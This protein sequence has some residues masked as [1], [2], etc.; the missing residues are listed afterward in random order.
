MSRA[1]HCAAAPVRMG[2]AAGSDGRIRTARPL[3]PGLHRILTDRRRRPRR[4]RARE[5]PPRLRARPKVQRTRRLEVPVEDRWRRNP[6]AAGRSRPA[7]AS[8]RRYGRARS[9]TGRVP[10]RISARADLPRRHG[11]TA[12]AP[13]VPAA[14]PSLVARAGRARGTADAPLPFTSRHVSRARR[15]TNRELQRVRD[16]V[17]KDPG[18]GRVQVPTSRARPAFRPGAARPA[19]AESPAGRSPGSA[20]AARWR[21]PRS[22]RPA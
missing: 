4:H 18:E 12:P 15:V 21:S 3:P 5:P 1:G 8:R 19:R 14:V 10:P 7:S 2:G 13:A 17:G 16:R 20:R 6:Q 11:S 22:S 9:V